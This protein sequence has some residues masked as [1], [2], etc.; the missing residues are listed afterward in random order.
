MAADGSDGLRLI[1]SQSVDAVVVEHE[2][3]SLD[4]AAIAGVIKHVRPDV[5]IIM[6]ADHMEIPA[7]ALESVDALVVKDDGPH[8]LLATV[9]FIL[10]VKPVQRHQAKLRSQTPD[11]SAHA[12]RSLTTAERGG[13]FSQEV[14]R[15]I[16]SGIIRF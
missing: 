8:F 6:L 3:P 1:M 11:R 5:P 12:G 15:S 10:T 14:W 9:H 7:T 2:P 13:P 16:K 4:G